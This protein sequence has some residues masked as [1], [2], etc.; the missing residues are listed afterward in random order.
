MSTP[1]PNRRRVGTVVIAD[2]DIGNLGGIS[3]A[4]NTLGDGFRAQGIDV[5]YAS[6]NPPRPEA[7]PHGEVFEIDRR[8][9]S[10]S[11]HVLATQYPGRWGM[12]LRAKR[13]ITPLWRLYRSVRMHRAFDGL[14]PDDVIISAKPLVGRAIDEHLARASR[15]DRPVPLHLHQLHYSFD[16]WYRPLYDDTVRD[17]A[18]STAHLVTLWPSDASRF[19]ALYDTEVSSVPNPIL[20]PDRA[21][22]GGLEDHATTAVVVSRFSSDKRIELAIQA[23]DR[24]VGQVPGWTLDIYGD[25]TE[26]ATLEAEIA[27]SVHAGSITLRPRV[28]P[29]EVSRILDAADLAVLVSE[30]EG[31]PMTVLEASAR[32]V[33]TVATQSSDSVRDIV[34]AHGYLCDGEDVESI[35]ATLTAAMRD[36]EGR[37]ARAASGRAYVERYGIDAIIEQWLDLIEEQRTALTAGTPA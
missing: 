14:G 32:G 30:S 18:H 24:A 12:R 19:A 34:G 22:A 35:T 27:R 6:L 11:L 37:A 13:M 16:H 26:K 7:R 2:D 25:G 36:T 5:R 4:I 1:E 9:S 23:F 15:A 29:A 31:L 21:V 20:L 28:T 33:P 8:K 10:T 17:L 3:T